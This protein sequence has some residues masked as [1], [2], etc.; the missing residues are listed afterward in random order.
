MHISLPT[1][2]EEIINNKVKSGLYSSVS[3]VVRDALRVWIRQEQSRE[4]QL[5]ELCDKLQTGIDQL[6]RGE[7]RILDKDEIKK[8]IKECHQEYAERAPAK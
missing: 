8:L 1:Q 6:E 4:M 3:E 7:S 2:M 5:E